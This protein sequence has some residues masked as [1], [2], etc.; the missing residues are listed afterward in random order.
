MCRVLAVAD[1]TVQSSQASRPSGYGDGSP[2][3]FAMRL[4][5]ANSAA[6]CTVSV[7]LSFRPAGAHRRFNICASDSR[8]ICDYRSSKLQQSQFGGCKNLSIEIAILQSAESSRLTH[9]ALQVKRRDCRH[10]RN[11]RSAERRRS[12]S[13]PCAG[14]SKGSR[15]TRS[16]R[17]ICIIPFSSAGFVAKHSKMPGSSV[18]PKCSR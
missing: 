7:Y 14:D 13:S 10:S 1:S 9:P 16:S 12:R 17:A 15:R 4:K 2:K 3:P 11:M 8:R 18:R 6:I 5:A